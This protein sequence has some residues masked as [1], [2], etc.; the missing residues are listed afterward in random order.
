M[1]LASKTP[2]SYCRVSDWKLGPR[3]AGT[4]CD[5]ATLRYCDPDDEYNRYTTD[6][7]EKHV[8]L[9]PTQGDQ[10]AFVSSN[11]PPYTNLVT[12]PGFLKILI[13]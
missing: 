5:F 12:A 1:D 10:K 9:S 4:S 13:S 2:Y 8:S 7:M 3:P 6:V 11:G